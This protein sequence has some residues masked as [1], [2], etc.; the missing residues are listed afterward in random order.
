MENRTGDRGA[1]ATAG[2]AEKAKPA[3]TFVA[4]RN[5]NALKATHVASG[6]RAQHGPKGSLLELM[7]SNACFSRAFSPPLENG[8][9]KRPKAAAKGAKPAKPSKPVIIQSSGA[10]AAAATAQAAPY[11]LVSAVQT[12]YN[13]HHDLILRA[14]DFWQAIVA[15][16]SFYING[17][18]EALRDRFVDFQGKKTLTI[19]AGGTLHTA[20]FGRIAE[21]MVDEQI[22]KNIKDPKVAAWLLPDFSTTTPQDRVAASVMVMSALQAYFSYRCCLMCGLPSVTLLGERADWVKLRAKVDGL[23]G[24]DLEAGRM[25]K[26]HALLAPITDQLLASFDGAPDLNF[27]DRV[28]SH[29]GGGSGPSYLSG[30][31]TAFAVFTAEGHWQGGTDQGAGSYGGFGA[32]EKT[33]WPYPMIDT[34]DIPVGVVSVPLH[35]DDNGTPYD[36]TMFAGQ[37]AFDVAKGGT[38]VQPRTDWCIA[39]DEANPTN[40]SEGP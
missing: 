38:G 3:R 33:P 7:Q 18:A 34:S 27:W 5:T 4:T 9:R 1:A 15:Q 12:A 14:D 29:H 16:F 30:W 20:D 21:R 26:W 32:R 17:N 35:V 10:G 23:L 8:S 36:T 24:F 25:K 22:V 28:C 2:T 6:H 40:A 13:E 39:F 31:I 11:G 19:Y 37:F